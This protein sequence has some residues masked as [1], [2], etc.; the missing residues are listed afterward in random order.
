[1]SFEIYLSCYK[2]GEGSKFPMAVLEE[3]LGRYAKR[4][5]E[6]HWWILKFP[7][8][9][10]SDLFFQPGEQIDGGM[11]SRPCTSPELWSGLIKILKRTSSVLYWPGGGCVVAD[12]AVI[13]DM[14][15]DM[16]KSLGRPVVTTDPKVILDLIARS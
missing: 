13:A 15:P 6:E 8:G 10:R 9:G 4:H 12:A 14:P 11:V 1:M 16:I 7:D 5:D 2:S 3:A